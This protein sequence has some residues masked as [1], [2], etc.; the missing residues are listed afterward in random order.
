MHE[1]RPSSEDV[2]TVA[3]LAAVHSAADEDALAAVLRGAGF[4]AMDADRAVIFVPSAFARPILQRLGVEHFPTTYKVQDA[5]GTWH[6]L[7]LAEEPWFHAGIVVAA[8]VLT[9]G[10]ATQGC[11]GPTPS[12]AEFEAVLTL[13]AEMGATGQAL[14][15][16]VDLT[17]STLHPLLVYRW[18]LAKPRSRWRFTRRK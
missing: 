9:H 3:R 15:R 5:S 17:A 2:L 7:P 4:T 1:S 11:T 8:A 10:Y 14:D 13:S 12:R 16:K 6:E 18:Q